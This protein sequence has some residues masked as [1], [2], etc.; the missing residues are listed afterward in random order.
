MC[1][2]VE[3][4]V[5][6]LPHCALKYQHLPRRQTGD[7][8]VPVEQESRREERKGTASRGLSGVVVTMAMPLPLDAAVQ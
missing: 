5:R 2:D 8:D 1:V 4:H 6:G 3:K 7:V